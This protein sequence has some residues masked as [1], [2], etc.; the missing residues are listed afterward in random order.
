MAC[1]HLRAHGGQA[2]AFAHHVLVLV[3]W[4]NEGIM[5]VGPVVKLHVGHVPRGQAGHVLRVLRQK[6]AQKAVANNVPPEWY[7]RSA[8]DFAIR[9]RY[10]RFNAKPGPLGRHVRPRRGR[11]SH[12]AAKRRWGMGP[13]RKLC[14]P[15]AGGV[16]STGRL[17]R[18]VRLPRKHKQGFPPVKRETVYAQHVAKPRNGQLRLAG[19]L[20]GGKAQ[21]QFNRFPGSVDPLYGEKLHIITPLPR[22][23]SVLE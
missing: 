1:V 7:G 21:K 9:R 8:T 20:A 10:D 4:G 17:G 11:I 6:V 18:H 5:P 23:R 19:I 14:G 3:R 22:L 2:V 12:A 15:Q 16:G 13:R